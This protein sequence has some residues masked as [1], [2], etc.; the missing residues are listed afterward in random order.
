M[1][2]ET[3]NPQD[4]KNNENRPKHVN[5]LAGGL[6]FSYALATVCEPALGRAG[7]GSVFDQIHA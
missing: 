6:H 7:G 3:Q 1:Q 4:Q 2:T 5:L